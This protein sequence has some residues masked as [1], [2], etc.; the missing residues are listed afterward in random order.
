MVEAQPS[1]GPSSLS[2]ITIGLSS[3]SIETSKPSDSESQ[4]Q[5]TKLVL[6]ILQPLANANMLAA[7]R[8]PDSRFVRMSDGSKGLPSDYEFLDIRSL[9]AAWRQAVKKAVPVSEMMFD[10]TLPRGDE[11]TSGFQRVYWE[12]SMPDEG[13]TGPCCNHTGCLGSSH[14]SCYGYEDASS[15]RH[16]VWAYV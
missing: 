4:T 11:S 1:S 12:T 10:L 3:L 15:W 8:N 9:N 7:C 2:D 14:N 16:T 5:H 6:P 13:G